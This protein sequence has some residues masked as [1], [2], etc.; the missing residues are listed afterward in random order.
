MYT[1]TK[2]IKM[3]FPNNVGDRVLSDHLATATEIGIYINDFL[4][5]VSHGNCQTTQSLAMF[6]GFSLQTD[7]KAPLLK[8]IAHKSVDMAMPWC[9]P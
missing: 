1:Y 6:V 3:Q 9:L 2:T 8:T 5:K 4:P 7:S